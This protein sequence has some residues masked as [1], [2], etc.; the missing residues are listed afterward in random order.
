M[1]IPT[2]A[3]GCLLAALGVAGVASRA[4]AASELVEAV[5]VHLYAGETAV[6]AV[7]AEAELAAH[8]DNDEARFALGAVQFLQAIEHLGQ[9]FHRYGLM[10]DASSMSGLAGLPFFRLPIPPNPKPEKIDY[11]ALRGIFATFVDN[12]AKAEETLAAVDSA[13]IDLPI[14]VALIRLDFDGDGQGSE[15]EALGAVLIAIGVPLDPQQIGPFLVDFDASDVPWL[16]A[17]CNLLTAIAEFPLAHDWRA[18]FEATF[19]DLFPHAGL[20]LSSIAEAP[21]EPYPG[22]G[23]MAD[24]VAFIHLFHWPVVEPARMTSVLTHLEAI[25]PLSRE[26]WKRILAE[27]DAGK[28]WIPNPRQ[29]GVLPGVTVTQEQIDGWMAFLDEFEALLKGEKLLPHW[30]FQKGINLRR[31]FLEPT[32]FDPILMIQG[33]AAIP[34]LEDGVMTSSE[35][36]RR[37]DGLLAGNFIGFALWFN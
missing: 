9:S 33:S 34:Y 7:V 26:N 28:E 18:G 25:P 24:V 6:A 13:T 4:E 15:S 11:Q 30:R 17:Y 21:E 16:R 27:T 36:W 5:Q 8:A 10:G 19:Q 3:A 1:R 35:T 14:N 31:I 29:T 22:F 2:M 12:L 20:P 37:I 32:T 23:A